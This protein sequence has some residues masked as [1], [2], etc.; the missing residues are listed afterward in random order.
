MTSA[1]SNRGYRLGVDVGGTFTDIVLMGPEGQITV[2]KVSSTPSRYDE[3]IITGVRQILEEAGVA[4]E[5]V[6]EVCHSTTAATNAVLEHRGAKVGLVTTKGFRDVLELRRLR[7]PSLYDLFYTPPEPLVPRYL[8]LEVDERI[9]AQGK[10][11]KALDLD[12]VRRS[13]DQLLEEGV[14]SMAVCLLNSYKNPVHEQ[15]IGSLIRGEYKDLFLSLSHDVVSAIGE[16][17]RTSTTVANA[18][19]MPVMSTYLSS[20]RDRLTEMGVKAPISVMQ[21]SGGMMTSHRAS[22]RPVFSLESG[23]VAGVSGAMHLSKKMGLPNIL[24]FDMGGTTTKAAVIEKGEP[25]KSSEYEIGAPISRGSRLLKGGG[26]LLMV[27]AVDVAEVGAGG[28]SIV[29][30]DR[31]GSFQV[32]PRSAGAEPGPICYDRGGTE[33]TT[34][35]AN[36]LLGYLNPDYLLGGALRVNLDKTTSLFQS[37]VAQPLGLSLLEAAY[38]V[39]MVA[40]A[41]MARAMRSVTIER[42]RDARNF[43][44]VAF[45]GSGPCHAAALARQLGI[46]RVI[47]PASPGLFSSLGLLSATQEYEFVRSLMLGTRDTNGHSL[48]ES[49]TVLE[50]EARDI[51]HQEG[52][53]A[54]ALG[55]TRYADLH[56]AA[57]IHELTVPVPASG[58]ISDLEEVFGE[59]HHRT[60]GY[61]SAREP[62]EITNIRVMG[63][64]IQS[65]GAQ[66]DLT[67][68]GA[69]LYGAGGQNKSRKAY[70]GKERGLLDVPIISRGDL[71]LQPSQGP[72]IVEEYD[73]TIVVPPGCTVSRDA[74]WN[75]ILQ[76]EQ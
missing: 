62:I 55:F 1:S 33:P 48:E 44:V 67:A 70:F 22:Q 4:P 72:A 24:T 43:T 39:H 32:G 61:Q 35:D 66:A 58:R 28:G 5:D 19:L 16:Y 56:Y 71:D 36:V 69:A 65:L 45:G 3:G 29:S 46:R 75:V 76:W 10:V 47:V 23:P 18:Y 9:D 54:N 37:K 12:E 64:Q 2:K 38:G 68:I 25:H 6:E 53:A 30:L 11:L 21:S 59:E 27:R 8:R 49:F 50:S 13:V 40:N 17:E 42:G 51:L 26:Y 14:E 20:L 74:T 52:Y 57:Q 60:Y 31:A 7:T 41:T 73:T 34:S 15:A 63:H